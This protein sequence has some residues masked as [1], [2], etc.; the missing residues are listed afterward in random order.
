MMFRKLDF[1]WEGHWYL[2][3]DFVATFWVN[4]R[5]IYMVLCNQFVRRG[6]FDTGSRPSVVD[7]WHALTLLKGLAIHGLI[8]LLARAYTFRTALYIINM[9]MTQ[10]CLF[11]FLAPNIVISEFL[12]LTDAQ[13]NINNF[14]SK[15]SYNV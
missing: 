5:P 12:W 9:P 2:I 10:N 11:H 1:F 15:L 8:C 6:P 4:G 13:Y 14:S 3:H 7:D